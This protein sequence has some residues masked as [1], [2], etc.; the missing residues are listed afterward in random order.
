MPT[1][2]PN[3]ETYI[4]PTLNVYVEPTKWTTIIQ[5]CPNVSMLPGF[6]PF[7][8][9][10]SVVTLVP[11]RFGPGPFWLGR[12]GQFWGRVVSASVG[13]SFLPWGVSTLSRFGLILIWLGI[14]D[15]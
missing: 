2:W 10:A 6:R 14:L 12:F 13:G 9:E 4:G 1:R 15:L 5:R 11:G 3:E 7:I 8:T